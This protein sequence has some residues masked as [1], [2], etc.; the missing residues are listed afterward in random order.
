MIQNKTLSLIMHQANK[1]FRDKRTKWLIGYFLIS[2]LLLSAQDNNTLTLPVMLSPDHERLSLNSMIYFLEDKDGKMTFGEVSKP[3]M[4]DKFK[5]SSS[6]KMNFGFTHSAFWVKCCMKSIHP[7]INDWL[8]EIEYMHLDSIEFYDMKGNKPPVIKRFGDM[9]PFRQREIYS[10]SFMI[11]LDH[12][13]TVLHTYYLRFKTEGSMQL[14]MNITREKAFFKRATLTETYYGIYF[15]VMLALLLYN[16]C[17]YFSLK[18]ISYLHGVLLILANTFFQGSINGQVYQYI[19]PNSMHLSNDLIPTSIAFSQF[20]MVLFARSFLNI[21]KYSLTLYRI[22]TWLLL[23]ALIGMFLVYFTSYNV[24]ARITT[25][26]ALLFILMCLLSG[27]ICLVKGNRAARIY[28]LAFTLFL[29]GAIAMSLMTLG[30]LPRNVLT[31]HGMEIGSMLN[32]IFLSLALTDSYK[33]SVIE[34]NNAREEM[35]R[36]RQKAHESLEIKVK[37]RTTEIEDKNE[38]LRQQKEEL[39]TTLDYLRKTQTQLIESEKLAALGGLVAGVAHEINTPVGIGVTAVSN[40]QEEIQKMAHLYKNDEISRKDFKEF[41]ESANDSALLIQKNLERTAELIQSFK[42]VSADQ[43]SEQQRVFNLRCYLEDIIRSLNPKLKQKEILFN[44][45]CEDRLDLNSYPGAFAQV[46]TNLMLNSLT[47]GF[48]ER[49]KGTVTIRAQQINDLLSI[50]YIDDGIGISKKDLPHI[51][52]PFYTSEKHQGTG[53]GLH[54]VYNLVKQKL[55]GNISCESE[56]GKGVLF[57]IE[58]PVK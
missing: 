24:S 5:P 41:L 45:E 44:I 6:D 16:L 26:S 30:L 50:K 23:F 54:I 10:R 4:A 12:P 20:C 47:H 7:E 39:Q 46:F 18:D 42:Q 35:I 36:M 1:I 38:E 58:V 33:I 11:Y 21:K 17:V 8:L 25:Q 51:F 27:I 22:M 48:S 55:H 34:N 56:T 15:G 14:S 29:M 3:E 32:W 49:E 13:D 9:Y 52:E 19:L 28:I 2:H 43:L 37:E 53:L 31:A 40:L 57:L